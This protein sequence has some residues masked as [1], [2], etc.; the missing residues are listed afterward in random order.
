MSSL[1]EQ[2]LQASYKED[3]KAI[4]LLV[5]KGANID[6]SLMVLMEQVYIVEKMKNLIQS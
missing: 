1:D 5:D 3:A 2:L 4:Q 6:S